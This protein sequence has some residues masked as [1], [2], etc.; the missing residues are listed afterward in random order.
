MALNSAK[1]LVKTQSGYV[2]HYAFFMF[3][4]VVGLLSWMI[5]LA[6]TGH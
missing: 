5:V 6:N 1:K 3:L 2:Y 4:G